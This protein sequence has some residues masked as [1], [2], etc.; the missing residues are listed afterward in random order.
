MSKLY[1]YMCI[2]GSKP[3]LLSLMCSRSRQKHWTRTLDSLSPH[4]S[5]PPTPAPQCPLTTS[6]LRQSVPRITH[7]NGSRTLRGTC[8]FLERWGNPL[9]SPSTPKCWTH[10]LFFCTVRCLCAQ[11]ILQGTRNYHRYAWNP[12]LIFVSA[13]VWWVVLSRAMQN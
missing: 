7:L 5:S 10:Q 6:L 2:F 12:L 13:H 9:A 3:F 11:R 4:V 8:F 1:Y